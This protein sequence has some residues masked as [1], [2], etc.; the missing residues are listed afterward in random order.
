MHVRMTRFLL[1]A[2]FPGLALAVQPNAF[3]ASAS[4]SQEIHAPTIADPALVPTCVATFR[5]VNAD[6]VAYRIRCTNIT[7]VVGAHIHGPASADANAGVLVTLFS[8][9]P[10][11]DVNNVLS[12]GVIVRDELGSS[13]FD[14]LLALMKS[15]QTYFN[16]H[17]SANAAGEVRGQITPLRLPVVPDLD[18]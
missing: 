17:T 6:R 13:A 4:P 5:V 16:V 11:G 8:G 2:L 3:L 15:D 1:L 14:N 18:F 10:T 9:G 12:G 7:Q